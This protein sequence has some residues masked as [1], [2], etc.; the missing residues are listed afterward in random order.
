MNPNS[1]DAM[2]AQHTPGPCK[3]CPW[4][5]KGQPLITDELRECA[6]QG[7]WFCCHVNMGT[8]H[9]AERF[10]ESKRAAIAKAGGAQ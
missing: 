8:C 1:K 2:S 9:G 3:A 7:Q 10:G 4:T 5:E 6:K